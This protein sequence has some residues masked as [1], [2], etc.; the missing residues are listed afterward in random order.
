MTLYINSIA[1][2][3]GLTGLLIGLL[4]GRFGL[5]RRKAETERI[6]T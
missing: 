1:L 2:I 3:A 6:E 4:V 5:T